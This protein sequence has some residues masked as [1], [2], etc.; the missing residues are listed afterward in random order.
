M[1]EENLKGTI[2]RC[3]FCGYSCFVIHDKELPCKH[4]G[5]GKLEIIAREGVKK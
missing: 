2:R 1:R 5:L 4:C 3:D